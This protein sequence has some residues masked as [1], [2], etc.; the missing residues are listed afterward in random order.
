MTEVATEPKPPS[1]R[2][3]VVAR[4]TGRS[5]GDRTP[6]VGYRS[7]FANRDYRLLFSG[8]TISMSGSWAYNVAL[9]VF[10][11][12]ATHSPAWVAAASMT[13]FLTALVTSPI[14]GLV[15][16]RVERVRLMVTLDMLALT[17][18]TALAVVAGVNGPVVLA[19][20]L[21]ALTSVTTSSYDP[22]ARATTP[23]IVGEEH[24]AAANSAQSVVENLSIIVG[25]A[26]AGVLLLFSPPTVVF[27]I[28]AATFGFSAMVVS[29][30][31]MRSRPSDITEGGAV[32]PL[33][34]MAAGMSAFVSSPKVTLLAG[35]SILASF[36][37][38]TDTVLFVVV[39]KNQLGTGSTGYGYLLAALGVGGILMAGFMNRI[40][41]ARRLG[42]IIVIGM[43][44]YCL[45]TALLTIV[46]SPWIAFL[47]EVVRGAGTIVVDVLAITA[48]QRLVNPDVVARVFGVFFALV[49][50]AISLG[51]LL[52]PI[53]LGSVGLSTTLLI[54]GFAI[55]ALSVAAYPW[56]RALDTR[57]M[58]ELSAIEPRIAALQT[59]DIFAG[60][61]RAALER[62][63]RSAVEEKVDAGTVLIREGADADDFFVLTAGEV[64]VLAAGEAG[65]EHLLG[66][67]APPNYFGEIGLLEHRPRTATVKTVAPCTLYRINGSDFVEAMTVATLSPSALGRAQA[68]L[69]RTHPSASLT[70]GQPTTE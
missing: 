33:K 24:L 1:I 69:A 44:V 32:G 14:G 55:P 2:R 34:Q 59:L 68:R 17:F 25:P 62:L 22:A 47:L 27:A 57:A 29:R 64:E 63:A 26:I 21:A 56:I 70:F 12:N 20:A 60:A 7:L 4:L 46:H 52:M 41:A 36:V 10:V 43:A 30:M 40:A 28:N 50:A 51:A 15:A 23:A 11:F 19:I 35:F 6:R 39:S 53:L 5:L 3:R 54:M 13:R 16:D 18:Q 42:A 49:L 61:T 9:I 38:G 48:L 37:Y 8:L 45:P 65:V 31:R 66:V 67:L 58:R